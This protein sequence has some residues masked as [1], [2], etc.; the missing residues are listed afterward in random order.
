M[1]ESRIL[2]VFTGGT[3]GSAPAAGALRPAG[4]GARKLLLTHFADEKQR[5]FEERFQRKLFFDT[6]C[7][8]EILSEN[9]NGFLG[10][11]CLLTPTTLPLIIANNLQ[12][13][14]NIK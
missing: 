2:V 1:K 13:F 3:I 10:S 5:I 6:V 11:T 7:P 12:N 14:N 4:E 8:Y 9:L